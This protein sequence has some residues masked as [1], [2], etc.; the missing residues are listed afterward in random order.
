MVPCKSK[1]PTG[2]QSAAAA[3]NSNGWHHCT[4]AEYLDRG[5]KSPMLTSQSPVYW[6]AGCVEPG[7]PPTNV[8]CPSFPQGCTTPCDVGWGCTG[9]LKITRTGFAVYPLSAHTTC[10][11]I[12]KNN[13]QYGAYWFTLTPGGSPSATGAVCCR[14][15]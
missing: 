1:S 7:K 5:G 3:C 2:Q 15:P 6:L 11:K 10:Y 9:T 12:G 13:S 14:D 4:T 8:V